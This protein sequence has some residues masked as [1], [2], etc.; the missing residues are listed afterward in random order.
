MNERGTHMV[1]VR[2]GTNGVNIDSELN[3]ANTTRPLERGTDTFSSV[4]DAKKKL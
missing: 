2:I 4:G 3:Y 1:H